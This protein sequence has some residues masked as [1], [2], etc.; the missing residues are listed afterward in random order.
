MMSQTQLTHEEIMD[1]YEILIAQYTAR[2][3]QNTKQID[4]PKTTEANRRIFEKRREHW[5]ESLESVTAE[6]KQYYDEYL[7]RR[8]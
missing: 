5:K 4:N 8:K 1:H 2:I 7:A 6:R 3:D